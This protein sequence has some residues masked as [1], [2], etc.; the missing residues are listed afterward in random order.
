MRVNRHGTD[1]QFRGGAKDTNSDLT[2]VG[3][4]QLAYW[5]QSKLCFLRHDGLFPSSKIRCSLQQPILE[6]DRRNSYGEDE[7]W[8][9]AN[10]FSNWMAAST[11]FS[12]PPG[13]T[14][15]LTVS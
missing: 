3:N 12:P 14:R 2:A 10:S 11:S 13:W 4:E 15:E 6:K 7:L 9:V 1:A 8:E 5:T